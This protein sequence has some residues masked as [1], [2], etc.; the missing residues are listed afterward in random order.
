MANAAPNTVVAGAR[1]RPFF[2]TSIGKKYLMGLTGLVWAG[3]I[4]GHMA[5]NMLMF[6]SA[7]M[8]NAY[9]HALTSGKMIYLIEAVLVLCLLVHVVCAV[10]LTIENRAARGGQRYAV[11]SRSAKGGSWASRTMAVQGSVILA[12]IILH[13]ATFKYGTY[14]ETNVDGVVMRDLHRLLVEVFQSPGY[15]VWYLVALV[16]LGFHLS[17]GIGSLFQSLG[18]KNERTEPLIKKVSLLY[19]I[20]VAGGFLAQPIYIFLWA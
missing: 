9:G 4:F 3:F 8:Y 14:Y 6:I 1:V 20:V 5:G 2:L 12:F 7:D 19:A 15:V 13:L 11:R 10:G 18:L 16:L 17:H